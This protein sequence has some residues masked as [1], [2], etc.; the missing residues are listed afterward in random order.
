MSDI[1]N[2][3]KASF[4]QQFLT[5]VVYTTIAKYAGMAVAL[6]ISM[7]L[8]RLLTPED[9]GVVAVAT[10][11]IGFI[12]LITDFGL[13]PAII[14]D[15]KLDRND[16]NGLF[17]LTLYTGLF[18]AVILVLLAS[19]I[20]RFYGNDDLTGIV[21]LLSVNIVFASLNIV[22]NALLLKEKKFKLVSIRSFS[23]QCV[24]GVVG[25]SCAF[26]GL[27][28]YALALQSI[29]SSL[30]I[31][32][33][34]YSFSSLKFFYE[35]RF[36]NI[37]KLFSFSIFQ[38][39]SSLLNYFTKDV[40]KILVGKYLSVSDLGYY[41]KSYRLMGMPVSN[42]AYVFTPIMQPMFRDFRNDM[43]KMCQVYGKL[44]KFL[45]I[46]AFPLA[47]LLFFLAPGLISIMYGE[48]WLPAVRPFQL[49]A[50]SVGFQILLS[51]TAP[52]YQASNQVRTM[53]FNCVMEFV[54][55]ISC[56]C[57][58]FVLGG[59]N[60]VAV[61]VSIGVA[62]RFVYIFTILMK[63]VFKHSLWAFARFVLPGIFLGVLSFLLMWGEYILLP[64]MHI[65]VDMILYCIVYAICVGIVLYKTKLYQ[66]LK[67]K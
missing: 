12:N 6:V 14:Q 17:S 32:V 41:E 8:A 34:N 63:V 23:M 30:G 20:A 46:I 53:F 15:D 51:T 31:F 11:I 4:R 38:F 25:I 45:S 60:T 61:L 65:I 58:G 37:K 54:I 13:G 5:G 7:I 55:S 50:I 43:D 56:L 28:V 10:V 27:G 18:A 49:L 64:N 2:K 36:N 42:L 1:I 24:G 40:D 26:F 52:I 44:L 39:L 19:P 16:L 22:P 35:I 29:V 33:F 9:F 48:Q 66:L 47:A 57:V 59:L 62:L 3:P 67:S 21:R